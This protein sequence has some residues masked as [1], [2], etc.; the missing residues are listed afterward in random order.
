MPRSP[1]RF[2]RTLHNAA[3]VELCLALVA[4]SAAW[5]L[6]GRGAPPRPEDRVVPHARVEPGDRALLILHRN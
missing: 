1:E 5:S 4:G 3:R 6:A 2:D